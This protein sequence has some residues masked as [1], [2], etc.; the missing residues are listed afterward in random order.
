LN[1]AILAPKICL[2][3]GGFQTADPDM[4]QAMEGLCPQPARGAGD[5]AT[6]ARRAGTFR[7]FRIFRNFRKR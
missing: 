2:R 5:F 7:F 4:T 3:I 1:P 6:A